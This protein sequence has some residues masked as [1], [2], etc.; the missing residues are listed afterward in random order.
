MSSCSLKASDQLAIQPSQE[1]VSHSTDSCDDDS[2]SCESFKSDATLELENSFVPLPRKNIL[3][4][5]ESILIKPANCGSL[6]LKSQRIKDAKELS[7]QMCDSSTTPIHSFGQSLAD[8]DTQST[9]SNG[10]TVEKH[11]GDYTPRESETMFESDD[12]VFG[13]CDLPSVESDEIDFNESDVIILDELDSP[14]VESDETD[15][16]ASDVN[17]VDKCDSPS[18][19]S[20]EV[21]SH[22]EK[23]TDQ[24]LPF[25][26]V[27]SSPPTQPSKPGSLIKNKFRKNTNRNY[28]FKLAPRSGL[29]HRS[30]S[31]YRN[32]SYRR[33]YSRSKRDNSVSYTKLYNVKS[34]FRKRKI[35]KWRR[36]LKIHRRANGLY[37]PKTKLL[38][39]RPEHF[40]KLSA[41]KPVLEEGNIPEQVTVNSVAVK[42]T[43]ASTE[44]SSSPENVSKSEKLPSLSELKRFL[45][46]SSKFQSE[47]EN[48]TAS[49]ISKPHL[50]P[51]SMRHSLWNRQF[52]KTSVITMQEILNTP[53]NQFPYLKSSIKNSPNMRDPINLGGYLNI[54]NT[55]IGIP[56]IHKGYVPKRRRAFIIPP[57]R[58]RVIY[59]LY[60][61]ITVKSCLLLSP[62]PLIIN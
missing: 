54:G 48:K 9:E 44:A 17:I 13:E 12:D 31:H 53:I 47:N 40:K 55:S 37:Q 1:V 23:L 4:T 26:T 39:L 30:K 62:M 24:V 42:S 56:G 6:L 10:C 7:L 46:T 35:D 3:V 2:D 25:N 33:N 49:V 57:H 58:P 38:V 29:K 8:T 16:T 27:H 20:S 14:F 32:M 18:V 61:I 52:S 51:R 36:R 41:D 34:D 11:L 15:V 60:E 21:I 50:R 22:I 45:R 43:S 5:L 19:E 59:I 28:R